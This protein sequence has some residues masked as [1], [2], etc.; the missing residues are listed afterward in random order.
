MREK[1]PSQDFMSRKEASAY[2]NG[3]GFP[4]AVAALAKLACVG[5]GPEFHKFGRYPRYTAKALDM[6]ASHRLS[7]A[8]RSTSE[9]AK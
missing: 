3:R 1:M 5:G 4:V 7:S 2:L 6:W 8:L 9:V